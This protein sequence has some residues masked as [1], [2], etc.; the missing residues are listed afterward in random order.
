M[1]GNEMPVAEAGLDCGQGMNVTKLLHK[2]PF[3][4]CFIALVPG[5]SWNVDP[6][7]LTSCL[8]L[9]SNV[10]LRL[11][12]RLVDLT[13]VILVSVKTTGLDWDKKVDL[14]LH[15]NLQRTLVVIVQ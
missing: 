6:L 3:V 7:H 2:R 12:P 13:V 1:V 11:T 4:Y 15:R 5:W 10:P 14:L 9:W 8:H